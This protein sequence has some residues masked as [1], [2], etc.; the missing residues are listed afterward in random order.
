M[1]KNYLLIGV[2]TSAHG[3]KGAIKTRFFTD[4]PENIKKYSFVNSQKEAVKFKSL[5]FTD[6]TNAICTIAGIEDRTQAEKLKTTELFILKSELPKTEE[7]EFYIN[8][9]IDCDVKNEEGKIIAKIK[10]VLNFGAGDILE[11]ELIDNNQKK[12]LAFTKE[13]FP[14][15][16]VEKNFLIINTKLLDLK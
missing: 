11:I 10:N 13:N 6:G 14:T 12:L 3:I 15:T 9:L 8:D 5:N 2:I 7:S 16:D 1:D 4:N